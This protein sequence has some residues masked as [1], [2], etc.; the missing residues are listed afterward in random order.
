VEEDMAEIKK[1]MAD[2]M[3]AMVADKVD[4]EAKIPAMVVEINTVSYTTSP[5]LH[6]QTNT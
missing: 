2:K 4:M 5:S 6:A 3:V 1:D